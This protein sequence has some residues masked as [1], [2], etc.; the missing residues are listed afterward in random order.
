MKFIIYKKRAIS[1]LINFIVID[2]IGILLIILVLATTEID[3]MSL[4][5]ATILI[6]L[7]AIFNI[8][9]FPFLKLWGSFLL[10]TDDIKCISSKKVR[11]IIPYTEIAE[12]GTVWYGREKFIYISRIELSEFQRHTQVFYLYRKTKDVLVVQYHEEIMDF[13]KNKV[14]DISPI[15][16]Q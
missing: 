9:A 5:V 7:I 6:L 14:P 15:M 10:F 12:Y 3:K 2:V 1:S 8:W 11:Q 13:L 4:I 16:T